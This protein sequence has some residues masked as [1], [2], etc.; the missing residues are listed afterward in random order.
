MLPVEVDLVPKVTAN[1]K[2]PLPKKDAPEEEIGR[3]KFIEGKGGK[4]TVR[5]EKSRNRVQARTGLQGVGM[6]KAFKY[7]TAA[8]MKEKVDEGKEWVRQRWSAL[9]LP[10]HEL[11]F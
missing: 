1:K 7:T 2:R 10:V 3:P 9:G 6:N 8:E 5:I 11:P 4:P